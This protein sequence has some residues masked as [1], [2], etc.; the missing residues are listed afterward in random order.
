MSSL[1]GRNMGPNAKLLATLFTRD[2]KGV[3][4]FDPYLLIKKILIFRAY[5]VPQYLK[6]LFYPVIIAP[7]YKGFQS[8]WTPV[9]DLQPEIQFQ[10][11]F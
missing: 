2:F 9:Y 8:F 10:I 11:Y 7:F 6:C 3:N 4:H 5:N 1:R